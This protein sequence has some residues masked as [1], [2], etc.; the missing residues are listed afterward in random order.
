VASEEWRAGNEIVI[1]RSP[2]WRATRNQLS[3]YLDKK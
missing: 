2:P 1:P 3:W